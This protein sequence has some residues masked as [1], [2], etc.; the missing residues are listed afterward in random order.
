MM[1]IFSFDTVAALKAA[2]NR[3]ANPN[4]PNRPNRSTSAGRCPG[5]QNIVQYPKGVMTAEMLAH[6]LFEE[7]A[8]IREYD[9]GQPRQRAEAEAW[10]EARRHAGLSLNTRFD[11]SS[12]ERY[13]IRYVTL[14]RAL[15]PTKSPNMRYAR[16]SAL[17]RQR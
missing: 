8:A 9:G 17:W 15:P 2:R 13:T 12:G 1:A 14:E 11:F 6:D 5:Q 10:T 4:H 7:R 3:Q 16:S